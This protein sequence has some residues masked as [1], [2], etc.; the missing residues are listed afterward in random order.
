MANELYDRVK[1]VLPKDPSKSR[2]NTIRLRP[3]VGE[4]VCDVVLGRRSVAEV[5]RRTGMHRDSLDRFF[6]KFVTDDIKKMILADQSTH[7]EMDEKINAG[8]DSIQK[9]LNSI[10]DE[11]KDLYRLLKEKLGEDRDIEDLIPALA[12]LLRDQGQSYERLLKS[13]TALKERTTITLSINE[14][15]DWQA[16]QDVLY[17]VFE[18][19]PAA[20]EMF[21]SLV[22]E[23]R[24]RI[25]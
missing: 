11:Q 23:R 8:Q 9:G 14:S 18:H 21:R 12:Q 17:L 22:Q 20:F 7:D 4:I 13:Y 24:L 16:L 6:K 25:E 1:R 3:D 10:I 5:S 2:K 15:P 19:H